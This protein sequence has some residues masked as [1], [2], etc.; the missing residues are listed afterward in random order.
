MDKVRITLNGTAPL[1]MHNSRLANPLDPATKALKKVTAKRSK[2]DDDHAEVARLEFL[3]GLYI[4]EVGPYLPGENIWRC[5]YDAAKKF[6]KGIKVKEG[7]FVATDVNPLAYRGPRSAEA[8]WTDA[9]FHLTA[10]AKNQQ[11][12]IMRTRPMF[13][14]WRADCEAIIDP[15]ILDVADIEQIAETAGM[16][17]GIGDWRPR[18]GRFAATVERIA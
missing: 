13:R 10:S 14:E 4:D 15:N 17:I 11:S 6:K 3:G 5:L 12:R 2:T 1:L 8:M 16:L 18:Y 9:N 7:L